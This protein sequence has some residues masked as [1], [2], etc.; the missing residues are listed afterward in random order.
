M[1]ENI[2]EQLKDAINDRKK[3]DR[4]MEDASSEIE[5]INAQ[6]DELDVK[7]DNLL[8]EALLSNIF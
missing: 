8:K 1:A 6:R 5:K 2:F 4:S 3:L 7:I